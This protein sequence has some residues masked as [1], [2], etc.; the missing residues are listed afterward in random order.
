M[1]PDDLQTLPGVGPSIARDLRSL[2]IREVKDLRG[3][4]SDKLYQ[5][6]EKQQGRHID[7]CVLYT[8]RCAIYFAEHPN[9]PR[10]RNWWN[11]KDR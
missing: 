10:T 3:K 9:A 5:K 7:R 2:G 1:G 6:M 8:F 4:S 11:F